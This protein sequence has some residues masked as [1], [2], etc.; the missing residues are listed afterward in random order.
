MN[1]THT[2]ATLILFTLV[3]ILS[4]LLYGC[5]TGEEA[6]EAGGDYYP[7]IQNIIFYGTWEMS[8][9]MTPNVPDPSFAW[10]ASGLRYVVITILKSKI[11]L[12]DNRIANIEDAV[13]TWNTG[14]G[15]GREGNV[16]FSDGR[17]MMNGEIQET[18]T[19]LLPGMYYVAAWAY[20]DDYDLVRSSKE[21]QY[22]YE[23]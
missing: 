13:W 11:D 19:P 16:S 7:S 10:Q 22:K 5:G 15:T 18:V 6:E 17:D 23:P 20:D 21:Y 12:R 14:L 4:C 3:L 9:E 1:R 2:S 8:L